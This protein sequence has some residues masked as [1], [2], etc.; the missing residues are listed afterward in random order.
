MPGDE[1][2]LNKTSMGT[3][4]RDKSL[5]LLKYNSCCHPVALEFLLAKKS[6]PGWS[7][8]ALDPG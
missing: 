4:V 3:P 5:W 7:V 1:I 6:F 8:S 2:S